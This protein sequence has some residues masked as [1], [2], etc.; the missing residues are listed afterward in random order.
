MPGV[1]LLD[2]STW[3]ARAVDSRANQFQVAEGSILTSGYAA[4]PLGRA[5]LRA[6]R[7]VGITV[8]DLNGKRRYNIYGRK[9]IQRVVVTGGYL[10]TIGQPLR[11]RDGSLTQPARAV[12]EL[13]SGRNLGKLSRPPLRLQLLERRM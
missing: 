10:H 8:Y 12:F 11:G 13:R 6:Q 3:T 9:L 1:W 4:Q 7:G 5:M 2:T